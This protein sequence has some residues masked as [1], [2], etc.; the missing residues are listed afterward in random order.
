M[1]FSLAEIG[2]ISNDDCKE[3]EEEKNSNNF[4]K[5]DIYSF[6]AIITRIANNKRRVHDRTRIHSLVLFM[7][8]KSLFRLVLCAIV[9]SKP[10]ICYKS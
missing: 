9:N 2:G 5:C 6:A 10:V 7:H 1:E 8:I 4:A 3:E